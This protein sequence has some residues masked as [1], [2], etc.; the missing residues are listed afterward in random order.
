MCTED[1][2]DVVKIIGAEQD[3]ILIIQ[4]VTGIMQEVIK[5]MGGSKIIIIT[6][7]EGVVIEIKIMIG[8]RVGHTKDRVEIEETVEV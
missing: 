1:I 7:I 2:Q 4:V 3:V 8:T 5:C 6:A